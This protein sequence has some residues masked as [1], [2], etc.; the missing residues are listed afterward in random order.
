MSY[1]AEVVQ[2]DVDSQVDLSP[3]DFLLAMSSEIETESGRQRRERL[4]GKGASSGV[5]GAVDDGCFG[6]K[7]PWSRSARH[8]T[9]DCVICVVN[10]EPMSMLAENFM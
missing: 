2:V 8:E 5:Y 4:R 6:S 1:E 10:E 7:R 9:T 3:S